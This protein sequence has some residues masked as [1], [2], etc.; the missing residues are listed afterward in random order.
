MS[1]APVINKS[2][3]GIA[4]GSSTGRYNNTFG[5]GDRSYD[6]TASGLNN[7]D[8]TIY[9]NRVPASTVFTLFQPSWERIQ[10]SGTLASYQTYS[11][12]SQSEVLHCRSDNGGDFYGG[13]DDSAFSITS[14]IDFG[15]YS[16][17]TGGWY[18]FVRFYYPRSSALV[19]FT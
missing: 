2:P 4:T 16:V 6:M 12:S 3:F 17:F 19:W 10:A 18:S 7:G 5:P 11:G 13:L 1:Y 8:L 9:K 15:A 14:G